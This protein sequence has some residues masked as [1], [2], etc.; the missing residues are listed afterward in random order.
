MDVTAVVSTA[1]WDTRKFGIEGRITLA[2]L[3][4][5]EWAAEQAAWRAMRGVTHVCIDTM[6]LGL[7]KP[8]GSEGVEE[9]EA[10]PLTRAH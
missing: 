7:N 10:K 2:R 4:P 9:W 3:K 8:G 6:R 5:D 1:G